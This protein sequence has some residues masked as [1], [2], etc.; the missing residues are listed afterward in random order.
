MKNY[1]MR[2]CMIV[3]FAA[4]ASAQIDPL[5][6]RI[7]LTKVEVITLRQFRNQLETLEKQLARPFSVAQRKQFLEAL[8][9][10]KLL[11]QA[12]D[13]D[14][15]KVSQPEINKMLDAYKLSLGRRAGLNRK[16]TDGELE[17]LLKKE[18]LTW[19]KLIDKFKEQIR[20]EK[21]VYQRQKI[22][23]TNIKKPT[24]VE[25]QE[26]YEA[27]RTRYPII[28]PEMISFKQILLVTKGLKAD[29][30]GKAKKRADEIYREIQN[31]VAFDKFLEVYLEGSGTVRVGGLSFETWRRNDATHRITYGK[32]F[33]DDLFKMK[34]AQRSRVMK[35]LIGYHLVEVIERI[36]FR[37]LQLS[38]KI[39]PKNTAAVRDYIV[40]VIM[41]Q[42]QRAALKKA[43]ADLLKALKGEATIQIYYDKLSW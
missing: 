8:V 40:N 18:N 24:D 15:I 27:N 5:L 33:F 19:E 3:L 28:S 13:R 37:V 31:G 20:V 39:P 26:Y 17:Q 34:V 30:E 6:A 29:E 2:I 10:N 9:D 36:P 12:A 7:K 25:I 23:F 32:S 11:L 21:L 22:F 43:T 14:L 35:S 42:A 41:Q 16:L 38:D 4:S 1:F